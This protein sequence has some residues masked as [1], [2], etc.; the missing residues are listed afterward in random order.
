MLGEWDQYCCENR[1]NCFEFREVAGDEDDDDDDKEINQA[2][3]N[4]RV[5]REGKMQIFVNL[6][7]KYH[8]F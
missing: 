4:W 8:E 1:L 7:Q 5:F 6:F 2:Q 3:Q